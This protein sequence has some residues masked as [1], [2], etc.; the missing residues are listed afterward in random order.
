MKIGILTFH[1]QLNYGGVLQCWAL[2]TALEKLGYQVVVINRWWDVGNRRLLGDFPRY[3][4][5][6]WLSFFHRCL[7][8]RNGEFGVLIRRIR[9]FRF[10]KSRLHLTKYSFHNWNDAPEDLGVD[11]IV[12]GS[13]QVWRKSQYDDPAPYLLPFRND[14]SKFAYAA[15]FGMKGIEKPDLAFYKEALKRFSSISVREKEG[16]QICRGMGIDCSHVVDPTILLSREQWQSAFGMARRRTRKLVVYFL[17]YKMQDMVM[18]LS[19][20]AREYDAHVEMFGIENAR[21]KLVDNAR[22]SFRSDAGPVEF[23]RGIAESEMVV[24]D[25]FHGLVLS[26]IFGCNVRVLRPTDTNRRS[27]FSRIE[28]FCDS[29]IRGVPL[30]DSLQDALASFI[31]G[32][33]VAYD[34]HGIDVSRMTSIEWIKENVK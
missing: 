7:R 12:V 24:T 28:E 29:F 15:S 11:A 34:Y 19:E 9:T 1:S 3:T 14:V 23:L 33:Q 30:A 16:M 2:Q 4:L 18:D 27:M 5:R 13:D 32:R 20:F 10:I 22:I 8:S 6:K 26:M 31:N 21:V 17:S 25:S